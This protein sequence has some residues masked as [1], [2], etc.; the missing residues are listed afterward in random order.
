[1]DQEEA[2]A[3]AS[4]LFDATLFDI[5]GPIHVNYSSSS[6]GGVPLVS[7]KDAEL[8]LSFQDDAITRVQTAQGELVTVTV[9]SVV[10]AFVRT[11]TLVVP[12]IRV[13]AGEEAEFDTL[14]VETTDRSGAF[15][16][17]PGPAGVL[18]TYRAHQ[19]RGTAKHVQF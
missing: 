12:A 17:P 6:F 9:E 5:V 19:V 7:Y 3:I 2:R 14:L 15:V 13:A 18:Q 1:M 8:D 11:V 4:Q 16:P 10:D